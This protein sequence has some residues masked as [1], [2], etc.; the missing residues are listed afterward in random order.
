MRLAV[1]E[2]QKGLG[3]TSPNPCVG[4]VVVKDGRLIAKGYH[5][6]AGT[7]HAEVHALN[8]AGKKARGA[9]IYVTLE[10]CNHTGRT[11]PLH[12]GH[13]GQR[14]PSG[15]GGHARPQPT[16]GGGRL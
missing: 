9:T 10:P 1:R 16:G 14:H 3:R 15:G 5:R 11:P 12:P 4:A 6:K 8:A 2:A 7:P 13:S